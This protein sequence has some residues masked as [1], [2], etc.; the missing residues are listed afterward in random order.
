MKY[1]KALE[2]MKTFTK[3]QLDCDV[4]IELEYVVIGL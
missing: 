1:R 3:E 2:M 4:T